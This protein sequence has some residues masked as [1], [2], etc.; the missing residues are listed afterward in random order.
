MTNVRMSLVDLDSGV[1][2]KYIPSKKAVA[3]ATGGMT[4]PAGDIT[5]NLLSEA[6]DTATEFNMGVTPL[7]SLAGRIGFI[8]IEADSVAMLGNV[9]GIP[10][11]QNDLQFIVAKQVAFVTD[12]ASVQA[13]YVHIGAGQDTAAATPRGLAVPY[14]E[15]GINDT[16]TLGQFTAGEDGVSN[17]TV[18][19]DGSDIYTQG[20]IIEILGTILNN[21]LYEVE[22]H[23]GNVLTPRGVGTVDTVEGF[24]ARDFETEV[25]SATIRGIN[26]SVMRSGVDGDWEE[27]KG[28][29]TPIT[30]ELLG[31]AVNTS[32]YDNDG[33]VNN[34]TRTFK[35]EDGTHLNFELYNF[36]ADD[37]TS[38]GKVNINP[39]NTI[40]AHTVG[41]GLGAEVSK[42]EIV[43][44]A[45]DMVV[46]DSTHSKGLE[47]AL[48]YSASFTER[49]LVDKDYADFKSLLAQNVQ[50]S[51][52]TK[53]AILSPA[54]ATT[55]SNTS[56]AGYIAD[57]SDPE[58]P[59]TTAVTIAAETG[60]S[61]S[62][63]ATPGTYVIA[64]SDTGARSEIPVN[65][66]T[67][68]NIRDNIIVGSYA[69][70][71]AAIIVVD[72][73]PLNLG[74]N[75]TFTAKDF[76][77]D[78][79]GP[80]NVNGNVI[81][82]NGA[83][84]S[85]DNTGG[86]IFITGSN[87]RNNPE[88]PDELV[89]PNA[90]P[91]VF[92]RTLRGTVGDV[93]P[94]GAGPVTV[95]DPSFYDDGSGTLQAIASN[96]FTVQ[97]VYITPA[98]G[99]VVAYGQEVFNTLSEAES[100]ILNG[101]LLYEEQPTV[102]KLVR[103]CF[104]AVREGATNLQIAAD[105]TFVTDGNFRGG[106]AATS[107]GIPGIN[108]PG[109]S[110]TNIQFNDNGAF[111]GT[112]DL[113]WDGSTLATAG[114]I[115]AENFLMI[116]QGVF[117]DSNKNLY[118]PNPIPAGVD[119]NNIALGVNALNS[120][121]GLNND[122]ISLGVSSATNAT[123][124]DECVVVGGFA[125]SNITSESGSV[126]IGS[127]CGG[128]LT[129]GAQANVI[130]GRLAGNN[131]SGSQAGNTLIGSAVGFPSGFNSGNNCVILGNLAA[132]ISFSGDRGILIGWEADGPSSTDDYLN[133]GKVIFGD[134]ASGNI[135]IGGSE[136]AV[137]GPERLR[138]DSGDLVVEGKITLGAAE[139]TIL[140]G[141]A[142][143]KNL[144][145]GEDLP[146]PL[147]TRNV[148]HGFNSVT[149]A[150]GTT[151]DNVVLGNDNAP[152]LT[153][154]S[155][156]NVVVGNDNLTG[157]T[158]VVNRN[159][160]VGSIP[161]PNAT[162][163]FDNV[164]IGDA[165]FGASATS[166]IRTIMVG[167][168]SVTNSVTVSDSVVVG[169]SAAQTAT[170]LTG[171]IVIGPG[172]GTPVGDVDDFL[173]IGDLIFGNLNSGK[174]TVGGGVAIPSGVGK[175]EVIGEAVID[176]MRLGNVG[177]NLWFSDE[178]ISG[179]ALDS[180]S[181]G[182]NNFSA[183]MSGV[184]NTGLG[185]NIAPQLTTGDGNTLL[186]ANIAINMI[187]GGRNSCMGDAAL[188]KGLGSD[189]VSLGYHNYINLVAGN[190]NVGI[191]SITGGTLT[192]GD[193]NILIG[194]G[195]DVPAASTDSYMSIGDLIF[196]DRSG[197]KARIGGSGVV[198]G[199]DTLQ[200]EGDFKATGS[201]TSNDVLAL[202]TPIT[203]PANPSAGFVFYVDSAD[204]DLKVLSSTG[205]TTTIA[206]N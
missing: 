113:T 38:S 159:V 89:I 33:T 72:P 105:A 100:A 129:S 10:Y 88:V 203:A 149:N 52:L 96:D 85:L 186:G 4:W 187:I 65:T 118:S 7:Q 44:S 197:D 87:F 39:E 151:T 192:N 121:V 81:G 162:G 11:I 17:P 131:M 140:N 79:I 168:G 124:I 49:S 84:L 178:V 90:S 24:T 82:A 127:A 116:D 3:D 53:G 170:S 37:Y 80:A 68:Q 27:G 36:D 61:A 26:V 31:T 67:N 50:V 16:V 22:D 42:S 93:I 160:V 19:T 107:S 172:A 204:G 176:G 150:D 174:L 77:R 2:Q 125:A 136:V 155:N 6:P 122:N 8:L 183:E 43:I 206:S 181:I 117:S 156:R 188:Q 198:T 191:G 199:S 95:I 123:D 195:V 163:P 101:S 70:N 142:T 55:I 60:W 104:L 18:I 40:I 97:V 165:S 137:A 73:T 20:Q 196:G 91:T 76:I 138:V 193:D 133:I 75:G 64:Y 78:V 57:F 1:I 154:N 92:I 148:V 15:T 139:D 173:N 34:Q 106:S 179:G 41:N 46:R 83:N 35:G 25:S 108:T 166:I 180:T 189:N 29:T 103:R 144:F 69:T 51:G 161:A 110:N 128:A 190:S 21:G 201:V 169:D 184:S 182:F 119:S 59:V 141:D 152:N 171:S 132:R 63:I 58:V 205:V 167:N 12:T 71:G 120:L 185:A 30:Y 23:T 14:E 112:N 158:G 164:L 9:G 145:T 153:N 45:L 5:I 126:Y 56:G 111:G 74:F 134:L 202:N 200:V 143:N 114:V 98:G 86:T 94:D 62:N 130:I 115:N 54:S 28:S 66:L 146:S 135:R 47:Y 99:Y 109:G 32:I 13:D 177:T 194:S 48:D 157:I 175:F 147:G 102:T